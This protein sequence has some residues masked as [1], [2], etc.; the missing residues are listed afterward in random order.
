[1]CRGRTIG[2]DA[3]RG[4]AG[5]VPRADVRRL[6]GR[7][8][9]RAARRARDGAALAAAPRDGRVGR[10]LAAAA[11]PGDQ[12]PR[13]ATPLR[14]QNT[15]DRLTDTLGRRRHSDRCPYR[16]LIRKWETPRPH[17]P[18]LPHATS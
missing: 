7:T 4:P 6:D 10:R 5:A 9:G 14:L 17:L 13:R 12:T 11:A 8:D 18:S 2:P 16:A 15:R 1:M 3:P